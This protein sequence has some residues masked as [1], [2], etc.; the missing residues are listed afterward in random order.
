MDEQHIQNLMKTLGITREEAI[1]LEEYDDDVN[2]GK[3]TQ[4]DLT[5]EQEMV[6]RKMTRVTN[7]A[8]HRNTTR[9]R[10][11]NVIKESTIAEIANFLKEDAQSQ[12]FEDVTIVNKSRKINF[13]VNGID[14]TLD[15]IEHRKKKEEN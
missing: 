6:A 15:L 8:K 9:E 3:K 7:N 13:S 2:H 14:Y 4:Y 10:K 12:V 1:E 11:P 5:P